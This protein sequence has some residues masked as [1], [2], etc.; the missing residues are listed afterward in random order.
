MIRIIRRHPWL[1]QWLLCLSES[2]IASVSPLHSPARCAPIPVAH[3]TGEA[4]TWRHYPND[5]IHPRP[6]QPAHLR[7]QAC[8]PCCYCTLLG[9]SW[10]SCL[11]CPPSFCSP[12]AMAH[13]KGEPVMVPDSSRSSRSHENEIQTSTSTLQQL[14]NTQKPSEQEKRHFPASYNLAHPQLAHPTQWH[15][16]VCQCGLGPV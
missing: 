1:A 6:G 4:F 7:V 12:N 5:A 9:Q 13:L 3:P 8:N 10:A 11:T 16:Q 2:H 14:E 15:T